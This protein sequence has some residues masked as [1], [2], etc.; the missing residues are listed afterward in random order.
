MISNHSC[1]T[2]PLIVIVTHVLSPEINKNL[3]YQLLI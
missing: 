2:K 3:K 1:K